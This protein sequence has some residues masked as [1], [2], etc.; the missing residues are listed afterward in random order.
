VRGPKGQEQGRGPWR[1]GSEPSPYQLEGMRSIVTSPGQGQ[2]IFEFD[3][4]P[5]YPEVPRTRSLCLKVSY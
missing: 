2:K 1:R 3:A 4:Y 5:A